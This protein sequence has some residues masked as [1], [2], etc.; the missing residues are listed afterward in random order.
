M[1]PTHNR[2]FFPPKNRL[3]IWF[4]FRST[5]Y[6]IHF[7]ASLFCDWI[8]ISPIFSATPLHGVLINHDSST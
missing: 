3:E 1:L 7:L 2:Q 4:S 5:T 8:Y 6:R